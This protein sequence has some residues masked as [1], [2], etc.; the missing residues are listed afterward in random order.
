MKDRQGERLARSRQAE[1][2]AW[3]HKISQVGRSVDY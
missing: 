1:G 3:A 2:A